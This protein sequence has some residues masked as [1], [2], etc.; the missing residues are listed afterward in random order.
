MQ[1]FTLPGVD[2]LN[3]DCVKEVLDFLMPEIPLD[4]ER[5]DEIIGDED[6]VHISVPDVWHLIQL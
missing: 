1:E 4:K 6:A 2:K 5:Q 3:E